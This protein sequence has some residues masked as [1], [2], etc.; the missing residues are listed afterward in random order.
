MTPD[1]KSR[2]HALLSASSAARW[3]ACPPSARLEAKE[4]SKASKYAD[5]GTLAH[6]VAQVILE[7]KLKHVVARTGVFDSEQGYALEM[8][9]YGIDY[10][11][12]VMSKAGENAK[13]E[14]E[15]RLDYSDYVPEGFGTG[16]CVILKDHV[17]TIID[18]KYGKGVKV[19]AEKNPQLMLYALGAINHYDFAFDFDEVEVC[20]YQP[21]LNHISEWQISRK[22]LEKWGETYVKPRALLAYMG[23]GEFHSGPHC[24]FCRYRDKCKAL[25]GY[26][27]SVAS[28][29]YENKDGELDE[30]T[31]KQEDWVMILKRL[32]VVKKWIK[33]IEAAAA[34]K[35]LADPD[36]IPGFKLVE[37]RSIRKFT[38]EKKAIDILKHNGYEPDEYLKPRELLG[39]TDL[40]RLVGKTKF[41]EMFNGI[42]VKPKGK[43]TIVPLSDKRPAYQPDNASNDFMN[44]EGEE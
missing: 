28:V 19:E 36:S 32:D 6:E 5:E 14:V 8:D 20:I 38:D 22:D 4:L 2:S 31:L 39:M 10:A 41:A 21:R 26:C 43:P 3:L 35:I 27:M 7:A 17:L 24:Q 33:T 16:D 9:D 18:Y 42:I 25:A 23:K 15:V 29:E 34:N 12:Y 44:E 11:D 40:T 13:V 37:G 1:H 30:N